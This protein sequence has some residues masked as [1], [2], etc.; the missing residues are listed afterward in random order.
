MLPGN[1]NVVQSAAFANSNVFYGG[2][3]LAGAVSVVQNSVFANSQVFYGGVVLPGSVTV[4][5]NAPF[6]NAS[7]F[8]GGSVSISSS[9]QTVTQDTAFENATVFY[10][11]NILVTADD[12]SAQFAWVQDNYRR[13]RSVSTKIAKKAADAELTK[14]EADVIADQVIET[15]KKGSLIRAPD[16]QA[17]N[18]I[19]KRSGVQYTE[20][21]S[22]YTIFVWKLITQSLAKR[23]ANEKI[24]AERKKRQ[25][26]EKEEREN[27]ERDELLFL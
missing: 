18:N 19:L 11:G 13:R 27:K 1:V 4:T 5:Q 6:T 9:S 12:T 20:N 16:Y 26:L 15:V 14:T 2:Q 23:L 21:I 8:H 24:N 10:G 7:V 17:I 3:V 25:A 22:K